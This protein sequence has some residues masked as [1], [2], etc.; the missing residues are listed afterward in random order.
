M[1]GFSLKIEG[2]QLVAAV[3][4]EAVYRQLLACGYG[5]ERRH[6]ADAMLCQDLFGEA[7]AT[8]YLCEVGK[9]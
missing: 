6:L 3:T 4:L 2:S 8:A 9:Q 1:D 5:L 7:A